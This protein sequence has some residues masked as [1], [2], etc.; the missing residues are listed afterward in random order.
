MVLKIEQSNTEKASTAVRRS[1][2][3]ICK[4]RLSLPGL[5]DLMTT[6]M[7]KFSNCLSCKRPVTWYRKISHSWNSNIYTWFIFGSVLQHFSKLN[8]KIPFMAHSN[9]YHVFH[10]AV[11]TKYKCHLESEAT[12]LIY[13]NRICG[14]SN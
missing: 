12:Y 10:S 4:T 6:G 5:S 2:W 11:S 14:S 9:D 1:R 7:L 3:T 13:Y 8:L